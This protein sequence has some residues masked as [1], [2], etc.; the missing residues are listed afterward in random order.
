MRSS[1][2]KGENAVV[3][4][5]W[6]WKRKYKLVSP[7]TVRT[8]VQQ[9]VRLRQRSFFVPLTHIFGKPDS[10]TVVHYFLPKLKKKKNM[11]YMVW[12]R[13][14]FPL[15]QMFSMTEWCLVACTKSRLSSACTPQQCKHFPGSTCMILVI[16]C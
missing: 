15:K 9:T 11:P 6:Q 2:E 16:T 5:I 1:L 12:R 4:Q 14:T 7:L 3:Q 8:C 13:C 10:P